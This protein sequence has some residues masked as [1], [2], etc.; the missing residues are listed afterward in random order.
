MKTKLD[1][2]VQAILD[3]SDDP[4]SIVADLVAALEVGMSECLCKT[5]RQRMKT[6]NAYRQRPDVAEARKAKAKA[7]REARKSATREVV[8][9]AGTILDGDVIASVV[10]TPEGKLVRT[11][12]RS[13]TPATDADL[14]AI[15]VPVVVD[16]TERQLAELQ[17]LDAATSAAGG[18][19][20][21]AGQAIL[22]AAALKAREERAA[23]RREAKRIERANAKRA[24]TEVPA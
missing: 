2:R 11:R 15:A 10:T 22:E 24:K 13:T 14:I 19:Q 6:R 20:T 3:S 16:G 21:D 18:E 23:V 7:R 5:C 12:R 4:S 1:P 8:E 17:A 9:S